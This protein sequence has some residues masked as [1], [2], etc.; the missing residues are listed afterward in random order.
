M[1]KLVDVLL[2]DD[3]ILLAIVDSET[4]TTSV[5]RYLEPTGKIFAD[6]EVYNFEKKSYVIDNTC[7]DGYYDSECMEDAGYMAV[8][9]G[10]YRMGADTESDSD[11]VQSSSEEDE[12][13]DGSVV[14]SE[15]D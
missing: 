12:E 3:V 6:R 15:E 8:A 1:V 2:E 13:S 14:E 7:I 9:G 11:Y 4:E 5:V 10:W